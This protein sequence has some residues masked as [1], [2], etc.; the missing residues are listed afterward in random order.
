MS[1][2]TAVSHTASGSGH[3]THDFNLPNTPCAPEEVE[4]QRSEVTC[5]VAHSGLA[6]ELDGNLG[7]LKTSSCFPS[8]SLPGLFP[9]L[10]RN[11]RPIPPALGPAFAGFA[12][13][14][15]TRSWLCCRQE[16]CLICFL[17]IG[18][19]RHDAGPGVR[20]EQTLL[21]NPLGRAASKPSSKQNP[22]PNAGIES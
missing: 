8:R 19:A 17:F 16:P 2:G 21:T 11:W 9:A 6:V 15:P 12:M 10:Q 13:R 4:A 22:D 20:V 18:S 14:I 5:P 7:G 1:R 3:I